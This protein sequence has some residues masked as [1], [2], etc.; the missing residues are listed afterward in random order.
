[1][2]IDLKVYE[3]TNTVVAVIVT[4]PT[5][6]KNLYQKVKGKVLPKCVS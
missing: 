2:K 5:I 6:D 3:H 1:M 4:G